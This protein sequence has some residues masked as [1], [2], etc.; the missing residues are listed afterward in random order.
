MKTTK[1]IKRELDLVISELER[2]DK[3]FEDDSNTNLNDKFI[4][5]S[6]KVHDEWTWSDALTSYVAQKGVLE[7]ILC[8]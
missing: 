3:V 1:Q 6:G 2:I 8:N 4:M 5:C 7:W